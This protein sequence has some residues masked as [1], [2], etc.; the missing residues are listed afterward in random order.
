MLAV[1]HFCHCFWS[2]YLTFGALVRWGSLRDISA[3]AIWH[4]EL[5]CR[6]ERRPWLGTGIRLAST[7]QGSKAP[8]LQLVCFLAHRMSTESCGV[9]R[10][11]TLQL[12][13]SFLCAPEHLCFVKDSYFYSLFLPIPS[14][15]WTSI[16][17]G[18]SGRVRNQ[19]ITIPRLD[20]PIAIWLSDTIGNR[21]LDRARERGGSSWIF[22]EI[23]NWAFL[24]YKVDM[25]TVFCP[26]LML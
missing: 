7:L 15:A 14:S 2:A 24:I 12:E 17:W 1:P 21:K 5:G 11:E 8:E 3:V 26:V 6:E 10:Q 13:P 18:Y 4:K 22:T 23:L 25:D 19:T 9:G 16:E 20:H